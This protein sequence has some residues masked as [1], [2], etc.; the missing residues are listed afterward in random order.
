M[1]VQNFLYL[2]VTCRFRSGSDKVPEWF[3]EGSRNLTGTLRPSRG[4]AARHSRLVASRSRKVTGSPLRPSAQSEFRD[5]LASERGYSH[6]Y[7][8]LLT[9]TASK[10]SL[11]AFKTSSNVSNTTQWCCTNVPLQQNWRS[12]DD[13]L[14][15]KWS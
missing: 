5:G 12:F 10:T 1:F 4:N 3:P 8:G 9:P 11:S 6:T 13:I 15:Q 2:T 14:T 7:R